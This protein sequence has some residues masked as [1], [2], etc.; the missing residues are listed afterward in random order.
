[1]SIPFRK[2][3]VGHYFLFPDEILVVGLDYFS[4]FY[5]TRMVGLKLDLATTRTI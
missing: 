2:P 1:M 4:L 3:T 5:R